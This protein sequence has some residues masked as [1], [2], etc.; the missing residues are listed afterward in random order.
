MSRPP[1]HKVPAVLLI[2]C[3]TI[4][5]ANA[6]ECDNLTIAAGQVIW[7]DSFEPEDLPPS[8]NFAD[9]Y[10]NVQDD[11][12]GQR[13]GRSTNEAHEGSYSFR[14]A[15]QAG[16]VSPGWFYRTFGRNPLA[17]QSH[18]TT[19]FRE[20]YWRFFV[21]YPT[22]TTSFPEK[23]TRTIIYADTNWAQAMIGHVWLVDHGSRFLRIDPASGTDAAGNLISRMYNDPNMRWLGGVDSPIPIAVGAWQCHEVHIKLNSP[24]A[25][26]GVFE[27]WLDGALAAS[28]YDL[29]WVGAYNAYGINSVLIESYWNGGAPQAT[30]RYIDNFVIATGR[31]GCATTVAVRPNPPSQLAAN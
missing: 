14:H 6:S 23:V 13:F 5:A 20:V 31:I 21:K 15:W 18:S 8:G 28:R 22:G 2:S 7:C 25:S 1:K 10:F 3:F 26:D 4:A 11:T 17:S 30:Q 27:L 9:N 24:G 12:A 29:N 19:D 16:E